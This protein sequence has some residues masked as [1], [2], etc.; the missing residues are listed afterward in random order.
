METITTKHFK[1]QINLKNTAITPVELKPLV[2]NTLI[3][4]DLGEN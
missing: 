1:E 3:L 2:L 4:L